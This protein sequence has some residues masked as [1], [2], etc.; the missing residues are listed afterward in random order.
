MLRHLA[1]LLDLLAWAIPAIPYAQSHY[2]HLQNLFI[3]YNQRASNDLAVSCTLNSKSRLELS[4]WISSLNHVNGKCFSTVDPDMVIFADACLSGWGAVA[5]GVRTKG[6]WTAQQAK[7]HINE[8][9]LLG[10]WFALQSLAAKA[11]NL[12]IRL[13]LNNNTAVCYVN[14]CGGT[15]SRNLIKNRTNNCRLVRKEKYSSRSSTFA[16]QS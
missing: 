3:F 16:G 7:L 14:K 10:A 4:W 13:F 1:S 5:N 15:K 9:E 12:Y 2:R 6:P 8:L 11:T